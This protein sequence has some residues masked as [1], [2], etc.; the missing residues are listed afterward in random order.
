[1]DYKYALLMYAKKI[2][3]NQSIAE[4]AVHNA[5]I[6]IIQKTEKYLNLDCMDFR[7]SAVIIV[8]NKCIDILRK[9]KPFVNKSIEELEIFLES[10]EEP[11][12]EQVVFESEYELIRKYLNSI[13]EISKQVLI[14]KYILDM[15]YKEIG[16][17]LGMTS[18]HVDTRIMRAKDKV[19]K[20][21]EKDV[22]YNE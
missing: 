9:Q 4:D 13:D 1:M 12:D 22:R 10:G 20:L 19:R 3:G 14:M 16:E 11:V 6:S 7:R 21:M 2:T 17:E 5:F 15:S 8:R 18:K